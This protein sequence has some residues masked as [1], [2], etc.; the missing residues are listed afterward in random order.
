MGQTRS[1]H[2]L[3]LLTC[4]AASLSQ[5]VLR[6]SSELSRSTVCLRQSLIRRG[7]PNYYLG[8]STR[9]VLLHAQ[10]LRL[11]IETRYMTQIV[12]VSL[13]PPEAPVSAGQLLEQFSR[14]DYQQAHN[15]LL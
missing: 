11:N 7:P 15:H 6:R 2:A 13:L 5:Y 1:M 14:L 4:T 9:Q 8:D 12:E 10:S 3:R